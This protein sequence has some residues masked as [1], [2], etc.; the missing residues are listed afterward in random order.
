MIVIDTAT[1]RKVAEIP[2]GGQPQDVTFRPDGRRA[3]VSNRLDDSVSVIDAAARKVIATIPVGD[4]PHG[5][6]TDRPGKT[7]YVLN[8]SSDDI[9]VIDATT[10]KEVKRLS[11]QPQPLVAGPLARRRAIWP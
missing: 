10:L 3:Y 8:T 9:S 1:R 6:L 4:E 7:L 2:V 5:M 11:R